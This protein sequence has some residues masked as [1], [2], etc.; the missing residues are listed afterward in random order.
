MIDINVVL[1]DFKISSVDELVRHNEDDSY[2][3]LLNSR[4]APNRL[5]RAYR[6]AIRHISNG[7]FDDRDRN[8][9]EIEALAHEGDDL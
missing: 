9:Q 5:E 4:Q 3:I 7:D 8:V 6:H 2:T 1:V